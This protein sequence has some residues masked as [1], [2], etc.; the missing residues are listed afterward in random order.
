MS[1][2]VVYVI[3]SADMA[4][5]KIGVTVNTERRLKQLQPGAL[6]RLEVLWTTPGDSTLERQLHARFS[7]FHVYGEWFDLTPLGDPVAVVEEAVLAIQPN[8]CPDP[9]SCYGGP[10][11]HVVVEDLAADCSPRHRRAPE[12]ATVGAH[13]REGPVTP[14]LLTPSMR[15]NKI[16]PQTYRE[17]VRDRGATPGNWAGG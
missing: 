8:R 9:E 12:S 7:D 3:G 16:P 5:V 10:C 11:L 2:S 13:G 1:S 4:P 14:R 17:V 15:R 6:A